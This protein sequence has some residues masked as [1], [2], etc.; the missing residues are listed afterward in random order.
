M[1]VGGGGSQ[2]GYSSTLQHLVTSFSLSG[3]LA[4]SANALVLAK[5]PLPHFMAN[6][7]PDGA[8]DAW[9]SVGGGLRSAV[10]TDAGGNPIVAPAYYSDSGTRYFGDAF[11]S[12]GRGC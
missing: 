11:P 5:D 10:F 4:I 12:R 1:S 2:R 9:I 3:H 6:N 7:E 8:T